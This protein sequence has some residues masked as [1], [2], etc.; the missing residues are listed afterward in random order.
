VDVTVYLL[1]FALQLVFLKPSIDI[2]FDDRISYEYYPN[3]QFILPNGCG[4]KGALQNIFSSFSPLPKK[5]RD[6]MEI[7]LEEYDSIEL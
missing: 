5:R 7:E 2:W 1:R 3:V 4:R 6:E